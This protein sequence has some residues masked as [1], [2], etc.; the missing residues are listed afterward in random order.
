[1]P[2]VDPGEEKFADA[3]RVPMTA[4]AAVSGGDAVTMSG[5]MSVAPTDGANGFIGV[6]GADAAAG[7]KVPVQLQGVVPANVTTGVAFGNSLVPAS[8]N[9]G[10][11][12]GEADGSG[13]TVTAGAGDVAAMSDASADGVALIKLP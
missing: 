5:E 9:G 1:M 6:A 13:G 10:A 11:F 3:D 12:T 2:E 8:N 7:E 4:T